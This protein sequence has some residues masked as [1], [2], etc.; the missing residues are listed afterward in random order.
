MPS[1][2]ASKWFVNESKM[3]QTW[4]IYEA[5]ESPCPGNCCAAQSMDNDGV[6]RCGCGTWDVVQEAPKLSLF[7][8]RFPELAAYNGQ[9]LWGDVWYDQEEAPRLASLSA[10]DH[11]AAKAALDARL[12]AGQV[13]S[14]LA[15]VSSLYCD[16]SGKLKQEKVVLRRC[17]YDNS[18][19]EN[20]FPAGCVGHHKGICRFV[21][22]DQQQLLAQ[23]QA[24]SAPLSQNGV[25]DF[26][27]LIS[28]PQQ[29]QQGRW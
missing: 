24:G 28:K 15:K 4:W 16:R 29:K 13:E 21:H 17:K 12:L 9:R 8:L 7:E 19:A 22:K 5:D 3:N 26:S 2:T 14:Y 20:G 11:A 6:W 25:R 1:A 10:A 27:S 18:P 23:L